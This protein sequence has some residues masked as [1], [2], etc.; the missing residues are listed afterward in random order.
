[1][2]ERMQRTMVM[3][4]AALLAIVFLSMAPAHNVE[5]TELDRGTTIS[6]PDILVDLDRSFGL[7]RMLGAS[8]DLSAIEIFALPSMVSLDA[9]LNREF[10]E[11]RSATN[12]SD[13]GNRRLFDQASFYSAQT[14]FILVGVVNRMDRAYV[15]P[16][17]CG[18]IRFIYRPVL[19][20]SSGEGQVASLPVRLPM[21]LNLV[22]NA[23]DIDD[24]VSCSDIARR[25]LLLKDRT[26][27]REL[28]SEKGALSGLAPK[29]VNRIELN[30]QMARAAD[31]VDDFEARAEYLM[32]VFR[33]NSQSRRFEESTLENQIDWARLSA[34]PKL[35]SDFRV[36]LFATDNFNALDRGTILVP[37]QYLA[38][39]ALVMTPEGKVGEDAASVIKDDDVIARLAEL[40]RE[41]AVL[42]NVRS[43]AG[44]SR[45]L[46]DIGCSGC[47]TTR[48]V[49]GFHFPG[50]GSG[51]I[52][53][54]ASPHFFG[55]QP[56]RRDILSAYRDSRDPDFSRG[57]SARPQAK[58]SRELD[59]TTY[60]NGW[61]AHCHAPTLATPKPDKSF[62]SWS[63]IDGLAC[64]MPRDASPTR[65]GFCFPPN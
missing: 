1:M 34:S 47:H 18:E 23:R 9:V 28:L 46:D 64:Q 50:V 60:L 24:A 33:L 58:R 48:A 30:I 44:F 36:W 52:T 39:R 17:T 63:C 40:S 49:G 19:N 6:D 56:R 4:C 27:A 32:K 59:G 8:S 10:D 53:A 35:A 38:T 11:F 29:N 12:N 57:F 2:I 26:S 15:S 22:L 45:R 5:A 37:D 41:G 25:W 20:A 7:G 31:A 21:T 16:Q 3:R 61:G 62:A 43:P 14:R 13:N 54:K 55:D 65:A 42:E 51:A